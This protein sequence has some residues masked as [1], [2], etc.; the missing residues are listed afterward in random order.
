MKFLA[1]IAVFLLFEGVNSL[2][3]ESGQS[4]IDENFCLLA[5][6]EGETQPMTFEE[7]QQFCI[8]QDAILVHKCIDNL[9]FQMYRSVFGSI[10]LLWSKL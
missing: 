1:V 2:P 6:V 7:A 5:P 4:Q 9:I 10:F 8:D 3:C